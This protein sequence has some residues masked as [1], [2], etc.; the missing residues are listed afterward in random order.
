MIDLKLGHPRIPLRRHAAAARTSRTASRRSSS[1]A[2]SGAEGGEYVLTENGRRMARMPLDP[3]ISRML[4][5][6]REEGCLREVAVIAAALSIRDPRRAPARQ[7]R[8][9]RRDAR[10]VPASRLRLPDPPQHL[11]RATTAAARRLSDQA[12]KRKFCHEHFLS[13]PRMREWGFVHDQI[14]RHPRGDAMSLRAGSERRAE[15]DKALYAAIHRSVLSGYPL[16]T[17]PSTRKRTSTRRPR[18]GRSWSFRARPSSA[19][20][21]SWIV[22]A[23]MVKTSRL[24]AR[25]AARDRARVARGAGRRAVPLFLFRARAGTRSAARSSP[26]KR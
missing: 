13:F 18:A 12:Q 5:E 16:A 20:T 26:R 19:R 25:T 14:L 9:G 21:R 22:A 23:E 17:S 24:Y 6:A 2:P 11:G 7:G 15:I 10:P 4:L 3:R 1:W 8:P